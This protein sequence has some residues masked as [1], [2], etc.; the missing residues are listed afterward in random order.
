MLEVRSLSK[1]FGE[2][3]ALDCVN[4]TVEPGDFIAVIGRSGAGKS[5]LLRCINGLEAVTS[6][7]ILWAKQNVTKLRGNALDR[8]RSKCAMIFQQFQLIPRMDVLT[9]VLVGRLHE[10][11]FL[12][13]MLKQFPA[14]DRAK[15][16]I[17]LARL[18]MEKKALQKAANLSGGQQQRVAI[19]RAMMQ[20][21]D[22]LLADEPIASLDPRNTKIVMNSLKTINEG[23]NIA[24]LVNLHDIDIA[25][26]YCKRVIALRDGKCVFDGKIADL[27]QS[28]L[29]EI[30]EDA[31]YASVD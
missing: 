27:D 9:N 2:A 5:T 7:D 18:G 17:E 30:Y 28:V 15:A 1:H 29:D 16:I 14:E 20:D 11:S 22:I 19:A 8:W 6:G 3:V 23:R 31:D 25:K 10:R 4:L 13:S 24:V 21:P 12:S 26:K